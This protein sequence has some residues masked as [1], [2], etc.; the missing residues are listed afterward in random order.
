MSSGG[1]WL[2]FGNS[3]NKFKSSYVRGFLD[4]C[5]NILV[6]KGGINMSDGDISC[7]GDIYVNRIR[8]FDGNLIVSSSG[9]GTVI[10]DTTN[11]TINSLTE[12]KST[13]RLTGNVGVGKAPTANA[14]DISGNTNAVGNLTVSGTSELLGSNASVGKTHDTNYNL[15]VN[16]NIRASDDIYMRGSAVITSDASTTTDTSGAILYVKDTR[17]DLSNNVILHAANSVFKASQSGNPNRTNSLEIDSANRRILPYVRDSAGN[18]LNEAIGGGWELGGPGPNRLDRIHARDVNISTNTLLIEDDSGNKIGMSFDAATGAVNYNVTTAENE[19]FTIKGVQTQKISSGGGTIDPSLLEFTGLSFGDTFD[20]NATKDLTTTFTYNLDTRTYSNDFLSSTAGTQTLADFIGAGASN[21]SNLLGTITSGDCVVIKVNND[22]RPDEDRLDGIDI[23]GS[24]VDLTDKVISVKNKSGSLEWK[25]WGT[26]AQL[27]NNTIGNFLNFIELKN[28]NMASGTYFVA[29]T[30]GNLVYNN[31]N[32]EFI[33]NDDLLGVVN[34]DLFLYIDREPGNN[35]TKIPVSLPASGSITTQMLSDGAVAT[36]KLGIVSV[37]NAKIADGAITNDKLADNSITAAKIQS[38]AIDGNTF[39]DDSI[40]G[41]KIASGTITLDRLHSNALNGKQDTLNA[42]SNITIDNVTNTIS[43]TVDASIPDSSITNGKMAINSINT[44][45]IISSAVTGA[46]I[47]DDTITILNMTA[48][49]VGT[50]NIENNAIVSAKITDGNITSSK[51]ATASVIAGKIATGAI[52]VSNIIADGVLT[53]AKLANYTVNTDKIIDGNI[54]GA[55][56]ANDAV[57]TDKV[58]DGSITGAKLHNDAVDSYITAGS[59]VTLTKDNATGVVTIASSGGGG[60]GGGGTVSDGDITTAKLADNAV[61]SIKIANNAVTSAKIHKDVVDSYITAGSNVTL[62]KDN[63]TGVVTIAS[64]GGGGGGGGGGSVGTSSELVINDLE[65]NKTTTF[66]NTIISGTNANDKFGSHSTMNKDG[67]VIITGDNGNNI[68]I[69]RLN[70]A[71]KLWELDHTITNGGK[72]MGLSG[73]GNVIL[74]STGS[75][76]STKYTYDGSAWDSGTTLNYPAK[77]FTIDYTGEI[78]VFC[79]DSNPPIKIYRTSDQSV[80]EQGG[81]SGTSTY[82]PYYMRIQ[83]NN[84]SST[85]WSCEVSKDGNTLVASYFECILSNEYFIHEN[86]TDDPTG[87]HY[88]T[89]QPWGLVSTWKYTGGTW[90][91]S[92]LFGPKWGRNATINSDGSKLA[93]STGRTTYGQYATENTIRIYNYDGSAWVLEDEIERIKDPIIKSWYWGQQLKF[94]DDGETLLVGA[95][96]DGGGAAKAHTYFNTQQIEKIGYSKE[97]FLYK[98]INNTWSKTNTFLTNVFRDNLSLDSSNFGESLD[99]SSDGKKIILSEDNYYT[100]DKNSLGRVHLIDMDNLESVRTNGGLSITEDLSVGNNAIVDGI[101]QSSKIYTNNASVGDSMTIGGPE[102][103]GPL[104]DTGLT[105]SNIGDRRNYSLYVRNSQLNHGI[106]F[107]WGDY[108]ESKTRF[109]GNA[110]LYGSMNGGGINAADSQRGLQLLG[111][112]N[113]IA[114][115]EITCS[116][117]TSN[118]F[119]NPNGGDTNSANVTSSIRMTSEQHLLSNNLIGPSI[120][121]IPI[122][123]TTIYGSSYQ[124]MDM[125]DTRLG[126]SS[127]GNRMLS[128]SRYG[129]CIF[130]WNRDPTTNTWDTTPTSVPIVYNTYIAAYSGDGNVL[131]SV[132]GA[133]GSTTEIIIN[134]YDGTS[135]SEQTQRL[136]DQS[137]KSYGGNFAR[138]IKLN[139]D[140]SKILVASYTSS[141]LCGLYIY[142]TVTASLLIEID[143]SNTINIQSY[144]GYY[145]G[146]DFSADSST[147]TTGNGSNSISTARVYTWDIDYV[148]STATQSEIVVVAPTGTS[149]TERPG[150]NISINHNGTVLVYVSGTGNDNMRVEVQRRASKSDPWALEKQFVGG[151]V[152]PLTTRANEIGGPEAGKLVI[153]KDG[154]TL[155]ITQNQGRN[156]STDSH[157]SLSKYINGEWQPFYNIKGATNKD[158]GFGLACDWYGN[159]I[160]IGEG[161]Y[162]KTAHIYDIPSN[163]GESLDIMST[164]VTIKTGPELTNAIHIDASGNVGIGVNAV[165]NTKLNVDGTINATGAITGDSDDRLK[166]NET[167]IAGATE[168]LMKIK[169]EIYD[170][171]PSIN[172]NNHAD[173]KKESGVIA[174]EL[175][176]SAPELRHLVSLGSKHQGYKYVTKT[177]SIEKEEIIDDYDL[178]GNKY[179]DNGNVINADGNIIKNIIR[180]DNSGNLI[181]SVGSIIQSNFVDSSGNIK[182]E[183]D[184]MPSQ[185]IIVDGNDIKLRINYRNKKVF[186]VT[187]EPILVKIDPNEIQN[188]DLT[189][190][191]IQNDPDYN[192][193]GWG[194]TPASVNY[195]GLIPYL[196]K[197]NQ[198]QQGII[199]QLKNNIESKTQKITSMEQRLNALENP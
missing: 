78:I 163:T 97:A 66:E 73:N 65:I 29:K 153:S 174:Q 152:V 185:G 83:N 3:S 127:D 8:D 9:S 91:R 28:I 89:G 32:E 81:S 151:D 30:N 183:I 142:D 23:S 120:L 53:G 45:N 51:L 5:G 26:L 88:H 154:S 62:T 72:Y 130:V 137:G 90:V 47:A 16:G 94:S 74:A 133:Q 80:V 167:L 114:M 187:Q 1:S 117:I 169:P 199:N 27:N 194:E 132:D 31:A 173:W 61:T 54:T 160:A 41:I 14:I 141:A 67:N 165:S 106:Q 52:N 188:I 164:S 39:A 24:F 84:L 122:L 104:L 4:I 98:K 196:I 109:D 124:W 189:N 100:A 155:I 177:V 60:G 11:L 135:W 113:V 55:K 181:D 198:E 95:S 85:G 128:A 99:M 158:F 159:R 168:T 140:G 13:S 149:G 50:S 193:Y 44:N 12:V 76:N 170:K 180:V 34:G 123:Q 86:H 166:E 118:E 108:V 38:G 186:E 15:D 134:R 115:N 126:M 103:Y 116:K 172:N 21:A 110:F 18:I 43:A 119:F 171:K 2:Q 156:D 82:L 59:N 17:T 178:S 87:T 139:E 7:N 191:D 111:D 179:D 190:V 6:R 184:K 22:D 37:T 56:L 105:S 125:F 92:N 64:S 147:V 58:A 25:V 19:Q 49:S 131:A 42:G 57:D 70:G 46:K 161:E 40:N 129:S 63:S 68:Y 33:K 175:W 75:T 162:G 102:I 138:N 79:H 77:H 145:V 10:D 195:I 197:S 93:F 101:I 69:Y 182:G 112:G 36:S 20:S 176:Y 136:T 150:R 146:C 144:G 148:N 107:P 121:S 35:W 157:V 71:S 192:A 96:Y 143:C 48:N